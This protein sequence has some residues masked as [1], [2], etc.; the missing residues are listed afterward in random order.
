MSM[1]VK[2]ANVDDKAFPSF[3][4]IICEED[5]KLFTPTYKE[6]GRIAYF[7]KVE[8]FTTYLLDIYEN[9][10]LQIGS[11]RI[12]AYYCDGRV[13]TGNK[14]KM[15]KILSSLLAENKIRAPF[16]MLEVIQFLNTKGEKRLEVLKKCHDV[17]V[18]HANPES[19][20]LWEKSVKYKEPKKSP[21]PVEQ[22]E[23][24]TQNLHSY[25]QATIKA[26]SG[27]LT[28]DLLK[29]GA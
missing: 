25:I 23:K 6:N 15:S 20:K 28:P 10:D 3:A 5:G 24:Y 19:V 7:A 17:L 2:Y 8:I 9:Y 18:E 1:K 4:F 14:R 29:E 26:L 27:S 16:G 12:F 22:R 11:K 13:Y 21:A